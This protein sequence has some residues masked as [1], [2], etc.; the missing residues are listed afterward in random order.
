MR[1]RESQSLEEEDEMPG[2][3]KRSWMERFLEVY[4]KETN[5]NPATEKNALTVKTHRS[6]ASM[7]GAPRITLLSGTLLMTPACAAIVTLLPMLMWPTM[8]DW[9]PITQ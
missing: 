1:P 2:K 6:I 8:P 3:D 5:F 9:P 4:V 7:A